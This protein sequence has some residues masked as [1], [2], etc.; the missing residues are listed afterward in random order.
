[1]QN[2]GLWG[3]GRVRVAGVIAFARNVASAV[4]IEV[5]V[6]DVVN[7]RTLRQGKARIV[8]WEGLAE[9]ADC[10][11][12]LLGRQMLVAKHEHRIV[13]KRTIEPGPRNLIDRLGQ[14]D[15]ADFRPGMLGKRR[16]RVIHQPVSIGRLGSVAHSL[17]EAS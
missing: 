16:D 9:Q 3:V 4:R 5:L 8:L 7:E 2:G 13:D 11:E 1:M 12:Q 17:S 14:I 6:R 10:R 15:T